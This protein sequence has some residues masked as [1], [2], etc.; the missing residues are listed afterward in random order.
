MLFGV[1]LPWVVN[2]ID[3]S[4]ILGVMYTDTAAMTFAV[5]GLAFLPAV[6]RYRLLELTPVAWATVVRGMNDPV[7]VIDPSRPDR[8]AERGRPAAL[9]PASRRDRSGST[10]HETFPRWPELAQRLEVMPEQ[11]ES[12][13]ELSGPESEPSSA[14]DARISRLGG[15]GELWG[16]VVVLRDITAHKRAAEERVRML[17]EQSARAEAEA[18]NRAKDRFLATLEP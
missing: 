8:R 14:F 10:L 11:G 16:W 7:V 1:I 9:G 4:Q 3:M 13:F 5:T 15:Q 12:S 18:A 6:L 17:F 2:M